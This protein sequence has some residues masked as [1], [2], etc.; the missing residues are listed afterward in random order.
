MVSVSVSQNVFLSDLT[1]DANVLINT[2]SDFG[3]TG[4]IVNSGTITAASAGNQTGLEIQAGGAT[5][6]GGGTIVMTGNANA[7]I[8]GVDNP[9]LTIVEQVIEGRGNVGGNTMSFVNQSKGL[10]D[11]NQLDLILNVDPDASGFVNDGT[12]QASN[13]GILR[14]DGFGGGTFDNT[15]GTIQALAGSELQLAAN[16]TIIGGIVR[17][18]GDGFITVPVSQNVFL[19]DLTLDAN[20]VINTNSDFGVTGNIINTGT[21]TAMSLGNQTGLEIQE[22]GA[23]ISG[24]GEIVLAGNFQALI[25]GFAP[26]IFEG[27]RLS[28]IGQVSVESTFDNAIVAAGASI[29]T[30]TFNN[31]TNFLNGTSIEFETSAANAIPGTTSDRLAINGDLNLES[32]TLASGLEI[33]M[34]T[35]DG[36]GDV[37]SLPDFDPSQNYSFVVAVADQINGFLPGNVTIDTSEFQNSF[38]G[39]FSAT[40]GPSGSD[41]AIYVKYGQFQLGDINRDGAVNLLDVAP[42]VD[43]LSN[44][45][46]SF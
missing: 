15:N 22:G 19:S 27:G 38:T 36:I 34:I 42:F 35:V 21:I 39:E 16:A 6:S 44:G 4:A 26:V 33:K 45:N 32:P 5:I 43:L 12:M 9:V 3:L 25:D 23:T 1:L 40:V 28:G 8:D 20:V 24:G 11:A 31:T 17:S 13:G 46:S 7:R 2:N 29:G 10:I 30:L 18:E 14:I 37:S 41:Q